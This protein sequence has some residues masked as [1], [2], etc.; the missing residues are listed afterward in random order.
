MLEIEDS[1]RLR[2]DFY[3]A[4][5]ARL[6]ARIAGLPSTNDKGVNTGWQ[7]CPVKKYQDETVQWFMENIRSQAGHSADSGGVIDWFSVEPSRSA[8]RNLDAIGQ[9]RHARAMEIQNLFSLWL[10]RYRDKLEIM[11]VLDVVHKEVAQKPWIAPPLQVE[12]QYDEIEKKYL[13]RAK[14]VVSDTRLRFHFTMDVEAFPVG[15]FYANHTASYAPL[16]AD[17]WRFRQWFG[18]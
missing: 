17:I 5:L 16:E 12:T 18:N 1:V 4:V 3:P 13:E 9:F 14:A 2:P 11:N 7:N 8:L 10:A 15:D 6:D